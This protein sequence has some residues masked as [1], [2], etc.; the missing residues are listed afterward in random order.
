VKKEAKRSK[1]LFTQGHTFSIQSPSF[2]NQ[3][4]KLPLTKTQGKQIIILTEN[5]AEK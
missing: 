5:S 4:R 3:Y 2:P 1:A